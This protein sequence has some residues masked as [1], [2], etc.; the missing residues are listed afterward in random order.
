VQVTA[1]AVVAAVKAYAK[2]NAQGLWNDRTETVN[3]NDLFERMSQDEL[4]AYAQTGKFPG[5]FTNS[6]GAMPLDDQEPLSD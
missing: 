6:V 3:L 2:I 4:E 5:W 1:A